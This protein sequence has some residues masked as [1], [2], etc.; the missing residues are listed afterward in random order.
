MRVQGSL[1]RSD[2]PPALLRV[3]LRT[4]HPQPSETPACTNQGLRRRRIRDIPGLLLP[5]SSRA[6]RQ[7]RPCKPE[8][9]RCGSLVV[10]PELSM[11]EMVDCELS[12]SAGALEEVR[13][14]PC[15]LRAGRVATFVWSWSPHHDREPPDEICARRAWLRWSCAFL[16]GRAEARLVED[17]ALV[18]AGAA[19]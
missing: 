17:C 16:A 1:T 13:A 18:G 5:A 19:A 6:K 2:R 9:R 8:Q 3:G 15:T 7:Q 10:L 12:P 14:I 4:N 11:P